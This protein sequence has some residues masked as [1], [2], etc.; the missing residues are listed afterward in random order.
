MMLRISRMERNR[1]SFYRSEFYSEAEL[2][3]TAIVSHFV[4]SN[5]GIQ[6]QRLLQLVGMPMGLQ[7]VIFWI[8]LSLPTTRRNQSK[9]FTKRLANYRSIFYCGK[10]Y[11]STCHKS[12]TRAWSTKWEIL[13]RHSL[14]QLPTK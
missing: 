4:S 1:R 7:V 12:K 14:I 5:T 6:V 10:H 9:T 13:K 8:G 11:I 3:P 2:D